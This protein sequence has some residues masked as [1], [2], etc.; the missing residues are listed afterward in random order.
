M[1]IWDYIYKKNIADEYL[2][3]VKSF[4]AHKP[5]WEHVCTTFGGI[6]PILCRVVFGCCVNAALSVRTEGQCATHTSNF[7]L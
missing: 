7:K 5:A 1:F 2:T 3:Q 4:K 6:Y